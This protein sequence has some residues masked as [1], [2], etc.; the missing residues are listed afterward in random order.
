[1]IE[2]KENKFLRQFET[3]VENHLAFVEFSMQDRKIFLTKIVVPEALLEIHESFKEQLL[4]AVLDQLQEQ[5][6]RI[7]PTNSYI[8]GFIRKNKK[9]Q[10]MLPVGIRV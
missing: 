4:T 7:V 2:I 9:Y 8:K 6:V 3:T 10:S 1:M 5:E